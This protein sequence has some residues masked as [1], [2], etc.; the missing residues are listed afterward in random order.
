[1]RRCPAGSF[2]GSGSSSCA[3]CKLKGEY[4]DVGGL[5]SCKLC[6]QNQQGNS[7]KTGCECR[8]GFESVLDDSGALDC[9]CAPGFTYSSGQC[10]MCAAGM[11]KED[12]GNGACV[13]CDKKAVKGSFSTSSS[14]LAA[15]ST[16]P[17]EVPAPTSSW[18]CTCEHGDVLL[19]GKPPFD[20]HFEGHGFCS[21][22]PEGTMCDRQG[23][24][25][26]TLPLK[27]AYWRSGTDSIK[28]ELCFNEEA[29]PQMNVT[30][31]AASQCLDGH[32]G[33]I[34]NVCKNGYVHGAS[35]ARGAN[36]ACERSARAE[37]A[38]GACEWSVRAERA[39]GAR[40][41]GA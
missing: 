6:P 17:D 32:E 37:R 36:G 4:A 2:S 35:G 15:V 39:S 3:P 24:T 14:M 8:P 31:E 23:I 41:R 13:S 29:C 25:L 7:A 19:E 21:K 10:V 40:E 12:I 1:M 33:P 30:G 22:C 27:P 11:F 18:N 5:S 26:E 28:I 34:C 16:R 38:S 20:W 9:R